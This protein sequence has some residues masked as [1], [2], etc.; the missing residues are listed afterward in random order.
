MVR[1]ARAVK[2]IVVVTAVVAMC[3]GAARAE[4][5]G[6]KGD[7][8]ALDRDGAQQM[9]DAIRA[10]M[11]NGELAHFW[12]DY[13]DKVL[14]SIKNPASLGMRIDYTPRTELHSLHFTIGQ[15]YL[16]QNGQVVVKKGR[17]V[18]PL[19]ALPLTMGLLFIDG[20]D[21]RQVQW[22]VERSRHEPLKIVLTAGSPYLMRVKYKD[23]EWHGGMGVP[24]YFDQRK[25][26]INTMKLTY[27]IDISS[28]P[29]TMRQK[30]D[31]LELQYGMESTK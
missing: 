28:V 8:Y 22:A 2:G 25:L 19:K 13:R 30:G 15:D 11:R 12:E 7:T 4:N 24:F 23:V 27:G 20:T 26:I 14:A 29:V 10:K 18:D 21:P 31:Q 3:A 1:M 6:V 9:R 17:V 16:D 5:L